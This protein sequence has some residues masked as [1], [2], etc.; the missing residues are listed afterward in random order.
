M[1]KKTSK[2]RSIVMPRGKYFDSDWGKLNPIIDDSSMDQKVRNII[3]NAFS[4]E[5]VK[6]FEV[7]KEDGKISEYI[8]IG[9]PARFPMILHKYSRSI[10][11]ILRHPFV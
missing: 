1:P 7:L 3:D 9:I 6:Q 10:F 2:R 5:F 4:K 8:L 11:F